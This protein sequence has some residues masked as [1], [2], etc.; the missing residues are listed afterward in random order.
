MTKTK[1]TFKLLNTLTGKTSAADKFFFGNKSC[2]C[3][4]D[5]Q[6]LGNLLP[7]HQGM[8]P[9]LGKEDLQMLN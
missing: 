5:D 6:Q 7:F 4:V 3:R 2:Q 9:M 1:I 8:K